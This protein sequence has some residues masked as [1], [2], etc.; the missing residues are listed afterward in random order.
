MKLGLNAVACAC[1]ALWASAATEQANAQLKVFF[2][3]YET[4]QQQN[5]NVRIDILGSDARFDLTH[6]ASSDGD[7]LAFPTL[8]AL[9]QYD[10]VLVWTN[11]VPDNRIALSN[12]L[13]DYVDGGGRVVITT[14]WGQEMGAAGRLNTHGYNPFTDPTPGN[15]TAGSL[16]SFDASDPLF[17]GVNSLSATQYRGDYLPGVDSGATLAGSWDDG[18]PLAG[19]SANR[20]VV[21]VTLYPYVYQYL[22]ATGDY[23][24]LF[25]NALA[26]PATAPDAN[27]PEPGMLT[28]LAGSAVF[29]GLLL[30]RRL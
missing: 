11:Q 23:R 17:A 16:G 12:R 10:A 19:Y 9:Q 3:G 21:N 7:A 26:F 20:K 18:R 30:R 8:A 1:L 22:H 6:S 2:L 29:G 13:A 28:L 24:E 15:T 27:T 4:T 14:F 25:R 5:N